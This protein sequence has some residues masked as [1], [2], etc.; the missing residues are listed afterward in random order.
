MSRRAVCIHRKLS[1]ARD[2]VIRRLTIRQVALL[3]GISTRTAARWYADAM[4][5]DEPEAEAL[6]RLKSK[7][8]GAVRSACCRCLSG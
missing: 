2:R 4:R 3:H 5:S 8:P 7:H 6:R 1:V